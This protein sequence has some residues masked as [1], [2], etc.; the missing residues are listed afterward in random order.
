MTPSTSNTSTNDDSASENKKPRII[1]SGSG[2][3]M[4]TLADLEREQLEARNS[5]SGG[6]ANGNGKGKEREAPPPSPKKER[7]KE[8][9]WDGELRMTSNELVD[10]EKQGKVFSFQEVIGPVSS[11]FTPPFVTP[12]LAIFFSPL[13]FPFLLYSH[14]QFLKPSSQPTRSSQHGSHS[15]SYLQLQSYSS[16][17]Q[18]S[19]PRIQVGLKILFQ[20][21]GLGIRISFTMLREIE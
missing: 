6:S 9:F 10:A 1:P 15:F 17:I 21:G 18:I 13:I 19:N 14:L 16:V 7:V 3:K 8:R 11:F 12:P 20:V 5:K 4:R 2:S